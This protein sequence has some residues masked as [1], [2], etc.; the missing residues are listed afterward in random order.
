MV[1]YSN[2]VVKNDLDPFGVHLTRVWT[3]SLVE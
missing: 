1:E 2:V 3:T